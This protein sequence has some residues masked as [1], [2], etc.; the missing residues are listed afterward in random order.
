MPV[1]EVIAVLAGEG[2][3]VEGGGCERR[4]GAAPAPRRTRKPPSR[5][6]QPPQRPQPPKAGSRRRSAACS[7]LPAQAA[8]T[9]A[10]TARRPHL[11]L[12]AGAAARQGG[13]HRSRARPGLR[14]ARPRHRARRRGA[15]NP[16]R[17]C[18]RR[19]RAAAAA[20][21]PSIAPAMSDQQ[22]RALFEDGSYEVVPHDGMRRTIAQRL[23]AATQTDPAFLSDDRLRHRQA[24]WPR[25]RRSTPPRRR[26][27]TAS[28][29]TSSRST[30][31]SSRRWRSR[32]S[33]CP[34]PT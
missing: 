20:G 21:A 11:R 30:T 13:R 3:D 12:A 8:P 6:P 24:R 15:R 29:P 32:C 7:R 19:R 1:N 26:T 27:R 10:P 4:Q 34:T 5:K 18:A 14:P 31:S 16:A 23:T 25:A 17:A 9:A 33:A 2:E 22:I 28:P